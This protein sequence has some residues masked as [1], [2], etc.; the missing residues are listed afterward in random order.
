VLLLDHGNTVCS[1][2]QRGKDI[3]AVRRSGNGKGRTRER[4]L[5]FW[6]VDGLSQRGL[7]IAQDGE[8]GKKVSEGFD[9]C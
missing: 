2:A 7:D 6:R 8:S 5:L 1:A 4:N 3:P 9:D